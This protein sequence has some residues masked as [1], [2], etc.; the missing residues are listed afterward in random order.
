[1][2]EINACNMAT[3]PTLNLLLERMIPPVFN[4]G[5]DIEDFI[6]GCRRL[7]DALKL[8]EKDRE[9]YAGSLIHHGLE[10]EYASTNGKTKGFEARLRLA[11]SKPRTLLQEW[12]E[13]LRYKKGEDS[14]EVFINKIEKFVDRIFECKMDKEELTKQLFLHCTD[15]KEMKKEMLRQKEKNIEEM[16]ET[17]RIVDHIEAETEKVN[18]IRSYRDVARGRG[19]REKQTPKRDSRYVPQRREGSASQVECWTCHKTGHISRHCPNNKEIICYG[20]GGE[21]HIRRNC[22]K[23]NCR[24]CGRNGHRTEDCFTGRKQYDRKMEIQRGH[25]RDQFMNTRGNDRHPRLVNAVENYNENLEM[26]TEYEDIDGCEYPKD[27]APSE[28]ERIGA[29]A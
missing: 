26:A 13:A 15:T 2:T 18:T 23:I 10:K 4:K 21:G 8:S 17:I 20:C 12:E 22:R 28:V 25:G 16:K 3:T 7:F 14:A 19:D 5:D 24:R 1:M 9:I 27:R 29:M 6:A 11:F